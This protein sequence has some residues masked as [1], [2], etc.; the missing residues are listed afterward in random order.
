MSGNGYDPPDLSATP[1]FNCA[2]LR[3]EAVLVDADRAAVATLAVGDIADVVLVGVAP[4]QS[5]RVL[6]RPD[7]QLLGAVLE[8]W[9]QLRD[10]LL[11]G[12]TYQA[13]FLRTDAPVRV[14]I[15]A[16]AT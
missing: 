3:F 12:T 6:R 5:L 11:Q 9:A 1:G 13:K 14:E 7:G 10:C 16:T 2:S 8:N 15:S 4:S